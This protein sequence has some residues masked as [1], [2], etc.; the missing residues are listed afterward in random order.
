MS[1]CRHIKS[2]PIA[3]GIETELKQPLRLLLLGRYKAYHL[4]AQAARYDVGINVGYKTIFVFAGGDILYYVVILC[5]LF[6]VVIRA[7]IYSDS[8]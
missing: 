6:I 1:P 8:F 7:H 5:I 2:K 3:V 4:L